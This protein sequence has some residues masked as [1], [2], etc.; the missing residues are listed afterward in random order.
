MELLPVQIPQHR[1][2]PVPVQPDGAEVEQHQ[3]RATQQAQVAEAAAETAR[4]NGPA[5]LRGRQADRLAGINGFDD[6]RGYAVG[7]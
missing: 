6:L 1:L 7:H 3:Q 4:M 5:A 2:A